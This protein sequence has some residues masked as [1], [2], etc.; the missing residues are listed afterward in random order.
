M[1]IPIVCITAIFLHTSYIISMVSKSEPTQTNVL[2]RVYNGARAMQR[3]YASRYDEETQRKMLCLTVDEDENKK[4]RDG[5]SMVQSSFVPC[6][7]ESVAFFVKRTTLAVQYSKSLCAE[8][9]PDWHTITDIRTMLKE[10]GP[11]FPPFVVAALQ[12]KDMDITAALKKNL[13]PQND[14]SIEHLD[15]QSQQKLVDSLIKSG[16]IDSEKYEQGLKNATAL[17]Y[18]KAAEEALVRVN[19]QSLVTYFSALP[20]T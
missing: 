9:N 12:K 17:A 20:K 4:T 7:E 8:Q 2:T 18:K 1:K 14:F 10:H 3:S 13:L 11:Y 5:Y 6:T 19:K 15:V 16:E